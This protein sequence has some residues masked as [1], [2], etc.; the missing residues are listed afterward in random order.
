MPCVR[1]VQ[2]AQQSGLPDRANAE[3]GAARPEGQRP[4]VDAPVTA[5]D[6]LQARPFR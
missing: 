2:G 4:D 6:L 1:D 3:P 5:S